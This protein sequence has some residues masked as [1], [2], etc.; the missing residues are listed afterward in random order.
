MKI[1]F[2]TQFLPY[3][4]DTGGKIKTWE[5]V[6]ILAKR[7]RVFLISF[8]E[9]KQDLKWEK[10]IRKHCYGTKTFV[11]PIITTSHKELKL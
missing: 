5:T 1:L 7:H 2:I 10:E 11:T 6:R 3:P 8:V 9:R 4:P